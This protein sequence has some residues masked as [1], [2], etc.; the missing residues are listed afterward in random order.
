MQISLQGKQ[1]KRIGWQKVWILERIIFEM[2][3]MKECR[4]AYGKSFLEMV[5]G[6]VTERAKSLRKEEGLEYRGHVEG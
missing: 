4:C 3:D 5:G 2:E 6:K 1:V